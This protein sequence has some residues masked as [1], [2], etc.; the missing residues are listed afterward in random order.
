MANVIIT[1]ANRGIGRAILERFASGGC[2]VWACAREKTIQFDEQCAELE[3]NSAG[4]IKPIYFDLCDPQQIKMG[5]K[6]IVAEKQNIDVLINNAAIGKYDLFQNIPL[7][8]ARNVFEVNFF[9]PYQ[10]TQYV[11]RK[12]IRQK[13]GSI[14]NI[15]S[16]ASV[17]ANQGDSVYG[18]SKAALSIMTRDIAVEMGHYGIRAN[19]VAPGPVNTDLLNS[20]YL[21]KLEESQV[22][23][24]SALK[25]LGNSEEIANVV[26][27]LT[28]E[29][30]SY[31]NGAVIKV[32]GGR[33]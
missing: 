33:R 7:E 1:G 10:I 24:G 6:Q 4:W 30:A 12:M 5:I 26:Y 32:D 13:H 28:T 27:F 21:T 23:E 25:R 16:T 20:V 22:A 2:N 29:E 3:R 11:L 15:S 18:A 19:V 9:A 14:V 17:E 8:N 31:I